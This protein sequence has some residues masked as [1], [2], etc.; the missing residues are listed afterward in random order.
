[1]LLHITLVYISNFYSKFRNKSL[2]KDKTQVI[3]TSAK[4]NNYLN[5]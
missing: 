4:T 5:N 3:D 1:M 2:Y